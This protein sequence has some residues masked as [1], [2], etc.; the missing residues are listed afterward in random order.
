MKEGINKRNEGTE[1]DIKLISSPLLRFSCSSSGD[2]DINVS[3]MVSGVRNE[4][5]FR[6]D[7]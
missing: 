2:L 4:I 7:T 6:S 3:E 1:E 5:A